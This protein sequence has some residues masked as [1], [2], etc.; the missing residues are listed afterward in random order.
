MGQQTAGKVNDTKKQTDT[1]YFIIYSSVPNIINRENE[2]ISLHDGPGG[3]SVSDVCD[4]QAL[5]LCCVK[6]THFV[7]EIT[8]T[9]RNCCPRTQITVQSTNVG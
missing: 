1:E 3:K 5:R 2:E 4:L 9:S 7:M 6:S 8:A